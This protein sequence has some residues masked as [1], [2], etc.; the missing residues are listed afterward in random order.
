[1]EIIFSDVRVPFANALLGE[2]RGFE[3]SQGRLGKRALYIL[4]TFVSN[5]AQP[6]GL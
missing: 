1:M 4:L 6:L 2:G 3:I 5:R